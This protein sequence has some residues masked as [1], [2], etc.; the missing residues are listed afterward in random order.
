MAG[1]DDLIAAASP[2]PTPSGGSYSDLLQATQGSGGGGYQDLLDA[3]KPTP[4]PAKDNVAPEATKALGES[5]YAAH[6]NQTVAG[7][8]APIFPMRREA[9][10]PETP[11][12]AL[13][14]QKPISAVGK[15][16]VSQIPT[17]R[18]GVESAATM[19]TGPGP[20]PVK[21]FTEA[22]KG[23]VALAG[24]MQNVQKTKPFSQEWW[25]SVAPLAIAMLSEEG[26]G[27]G[28]KIKP[29]VQTGEVIPSATKNQI[30]A[31][32]PL[33]TIGREPADRPATQQTTQGIAQQEGPS[34]EELKYGPPKEVTPV[35][36][37]ISQQPADR[38]AVAGTE[39][40]APQVQVVIPTPEE[41]GGIVEKEEGKRPDAAPVSET[42]PAYGGVEEED[43][44]ALTGTGP[45][46]APVGPASD[47]SRQ[48][49]RTTGVIKP[50]EA[51]QPIR[52]FQA[53]KAL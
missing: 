22:A 48:I 46:A 53:L 41:G 19:M 21:W 6:Q 4:S 49:G 29:P 13:E 25:D 12:W 32:S 31:A 14:I 3:T 10:M 52:Q 30:S 38:Q 18:E 51:P 34:A 44:D 45:A 42:Q 8:D 50:R 7:T 37:E 39:G 33:P 23:G 17:S 11:A 28:T 26:V 47:L 5:E 2:S 16:L 1:Y 9:V 36:E 35:E 15:A 43:R 20:D 27:F 24:H 40:Q